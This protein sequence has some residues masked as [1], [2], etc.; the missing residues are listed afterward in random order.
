MTALFLAQFWGLVFIIMSVGMFIRRENVRAIVKM[1]QDEGILVFSGFIGVMLGIGHI[2]LFNEWSSDW[3]VIITLI[4][5]VSL[6]KGII[7][8]FI[9]KWTQKFVKNFHSTSS[10]TTSALIIIFILGLYL[11]V[12]GFGLS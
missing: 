6:F 5:W 4:G 3:T 9:P 1:A 12:K 8:V 10:N 2:L 11:A 7:R